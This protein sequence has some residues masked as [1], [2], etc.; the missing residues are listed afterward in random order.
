MKFRHMAIKTADFVGKDANPNP[1][2]AIDSPAI[3]RKS[4]VFQKFSPDGN[5]IWSVSRHHSDVT[6]IP[7]TQI[8]FSTNQSDSAGHLGFS[9]GMQF[10]FQ[11]ASSLDLSEREGEC[12]MVLGDRVGEHESRIG[13]N[14]D[15]SSF[16]CAF[17]V[18][19]AFEV[20]E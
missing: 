7:L 9:S 10:A 13:D 12:I 4:L 14:D 20:K 3:G 6:L 2:I 17:L 18:G 8:K 5:P 1:I 19:F 15:Q 16:T 11:I